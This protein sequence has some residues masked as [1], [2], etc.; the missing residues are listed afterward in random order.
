MRVGHPG[1][2]PVQNSEL[3]KTNKSDRTAKA[4]EIAKKRGREI[5]SGDG[6]SA[7]I[8]SKGKEFARAREIAA[9]SPDVREEKI[10][11]LRRRI[12]EGKYSVDNK[13]VADRLVDEHIKM[14]GM[15]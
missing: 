3:S 2:N 4:D 10:A 5:H 15:S 6:G 7:E 9:K 1:N 14:S 11:E 8:S 12:A 13:A